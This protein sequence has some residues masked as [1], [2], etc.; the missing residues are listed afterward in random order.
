MREGITQQ[1]VRNCDEKAS[2]TIDKVGN[3]YIIETRQIEIAK[4]YFGEE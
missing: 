2:V 4:R 1:D 3:G